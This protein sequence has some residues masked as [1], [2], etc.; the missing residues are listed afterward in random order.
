M[1]AATESEVREEH[2]IIQL[3]A[4]GCGGGDGGGGGGDRGDDKVGEEILLMM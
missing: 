3:L 4:T 2:S 1:A